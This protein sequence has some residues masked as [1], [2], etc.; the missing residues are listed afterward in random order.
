MEEPRL[1]LI[2][3][4][5][6]RRDATSDFDLFERHAAAIM[7]GHGGRI[8]QVVRLDGD[9][10]GATFREVHTVSF[11]DEPSFHAYRNDPALGGWKD[12]RER[13]ILHTEFV[14]A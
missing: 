3:T 7:S 4:L 1:I 9:E 13:T 12:L 8:E 11:P 10:S 14:R 2:V 5:T 6:V